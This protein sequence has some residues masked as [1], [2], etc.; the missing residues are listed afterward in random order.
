MDVE[1]EAETDLPEQRHLLGVVEPDV[2]AVAL[3]RD[4]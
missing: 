1:V 4:F 2:D 3:L